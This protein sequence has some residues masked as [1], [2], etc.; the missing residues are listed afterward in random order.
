MRIEAKIIKMYPTRRGTSQKGNAYC[1]TD[2]HIKFTHKEPGCQEQEHNV[3]ACL[4]GEPDV[5]LI[6]SAINNGKT[7]TMTIY[8]DV[9]EWAPDRAQTQARVYLPEGYIA[10][11][12]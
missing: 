12:L 4:S 6:N 10:K 1:M 11:P 3:I 5:E 2:L 7:L 9:R 8:F